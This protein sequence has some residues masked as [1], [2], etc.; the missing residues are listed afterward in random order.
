[1]FVLFRYVLRTA[2]AIGVHSAIA[3]KKLSPANRA[4]ILCAANVVVIAFAYTAIVAAVFF[5]H[6]R[7]IIVLIAGFYA[8]IIRISMPDMRY[9]APISRRHSLLARTAFG[10]FIILILFF[11]TH[12]L[13]VKTN[14]KLC[15]HGGTPAAPG[16]LCANDAWL[17]QGL[18]SCKQRHRD[19]V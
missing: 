18:G 2:N 11:H 17:H 15:V 8:A 1:M 14:N 4:A 12:N 7:E 10:I 6:F 5:G 9:Q 19:T 16:G 13:Q 3:E